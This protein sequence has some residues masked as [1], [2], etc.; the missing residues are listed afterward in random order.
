MSDKYKPGGPSRKYL[1]QLKLDTQR[2]LNEAWA[3]I[4]HLI[5]DQP[6]EKVLSDAMKPIEPVNWDKELLELK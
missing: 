3:D 1:S 4:A 5:V 6:M 2:E